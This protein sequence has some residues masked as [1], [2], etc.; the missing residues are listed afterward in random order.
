MTRLA[1]ARRSSPNSDIQNNVQPIRRT[2]YFVRRQAGWIRLQAASPVQALDRAPRTIVWP[3]R[4]IVVEIPKPR[5]PGFLSA[6]I[7]VVCD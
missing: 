2:A 4:N 5:G 1:S 6:G 3:A 7:A